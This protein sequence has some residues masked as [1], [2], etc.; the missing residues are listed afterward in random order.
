MKIDLENNGPFT[1]IL[2]SEELGLWK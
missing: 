2:D 1:T